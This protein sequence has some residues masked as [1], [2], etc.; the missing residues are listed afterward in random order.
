MSKGVNAKQG[1]GED[2]RTVARHTYVMP[3][4]CPELMRLWL[5]SSFRGSH[6]RL[7]V[8]WLSF[9]YEGQNFG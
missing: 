9:A 3:V 6:T 1:A 4:N 7:R 2:N 5:S 8:Q